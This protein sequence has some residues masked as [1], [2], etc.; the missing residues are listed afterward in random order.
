MPLSV[1][2]PICLRLLWKFFVTITKALTTT[3]V[4]LRFTRHNRATS[5][6]LFQLFLFFSSMGASPGT[7]MSIII[8]III[9]QMKRFSSGGCYADITPKE[10]AI[11]NGQ[12]SFVSFLLLQLSNSFLRILAVPN[13]AVFCNSPVLIVTA[14]FSS[15]ASNLLLT[16]PSAPT[17]TGTTS[18]CLIPHSLPIS[19]L[20]S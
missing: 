1:D 6:L 11:A 2:T 18:R 13:K 16:T 20:R 17:T 10:R 9:M 4:T 14:S 15:H 12:R 3:C 7:A 8:I 19:L 5:Q